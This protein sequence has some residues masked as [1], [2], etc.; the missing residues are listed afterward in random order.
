METF[1][2][3]NQFSGNEV[4]TF[5]EKSTFKS[6]PN[7]VELHLCKNPSLYWLHP[8]AW[9]LDDNT[10][11]FRFNL[12]ILDLSGNRLSYLPSMLL[13]SFSDWYRLEVIN[14][15]D[16]P[17]KCNC[18]NEWMFKTIVPW[19]YNNTPQLLESNNQLSIYHE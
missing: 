13:T 16:N 9:P 15:Q 1:I 4:L 14:L 7:L 3:L 12:N 11:D 5:V 17:W 10:S 19:I 18:H 6:T 8:E 2:N